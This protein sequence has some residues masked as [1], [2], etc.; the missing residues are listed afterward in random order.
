MTDAQIVKRAKYKSSVK[1]PGVRGI[2]KMTR[3]RF[4]FMPNDPSLPIRLNVEFRLIKG[5]KSSKEGSNRPA[6][7]NLTQDQGNYIFEFENFSDREL[8]RDFVAKAITS[9]GEVGGPTSEKAVPLKDEQLSSAEMERRIKLLQEDSELQKLH[10]QFVIGGVL[11]ETEFWATRKKLLDVSASRKAKQRV[12]LKSDMIFNVKPSSDG[13]SNRVTFNLTPEM[14]HQIF[15]EKPAVRQAYLNFVPNKMTEKDFWTKYW[16]AQ[17]LHSTKNIVAAAAE[18]A[19]DEELA[20]FLKQDAILA[21]ETRQ[22]IRKVDPTLDMEADEGDDY[23]HI[24][25]H[26]LAT[27]STKDEME[28]QYE[29]YKRSFLQDINRHAAVV[30]EGRTVDV[31]T[32]DTRSVA[33]A[34]AS[35]KRIELAKEA[36][37]GNVY[38]E[39]LDRITRMAEIEDLQAPRDPPVAPLCIKDPRDYFDSQQVQLGGTRQVKSRLSTSEAYGSLRVFISEIRNIGLNDPIVK[40]EVAI[41]VFN[42]LTQNISSSKYQLGKNPHESILDTLPSVTKEELLLHWTS[43]QEL[44]K[45]FWSSYPIT[46]SYLYAKVSRL[47]DAMSQ[48]YPKLQEIKESV[49]SDSRHQVS[50]LVQPMLQALDAAF[51][52]YDLDQQKRSA[53]SGEKPN[54]YA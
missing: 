27:E 54:G 51:A 1:D 18:A 49:Q 22:K 25:G 38:Q 23:T 19:E 34:L 26:G 40:P 35:S 45:H 8:C 11:S 17:Y 14:I 2:L 50:L 33:E 48:I 15:A 37:D 29:P 7:L 5:H 46:T 28:A 10:K 21:S 36:S 43:I 44:L 16:R 12:G 42:V 39:R 13:Q 20:V 9:S 53:K 30:L 32:G 52:H 47:K 41:K 4:V 24:P 31:E 3:E 6:L